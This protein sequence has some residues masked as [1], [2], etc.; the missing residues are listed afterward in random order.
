MYT[1]GGHDPETT[2]AMVHAG[3][4]GQ[5]EKSWVTETYGVTS[6]SSS[7]HAL[8]LR[9]PNEHMS[10]DGLGPWLYVL[11]HSSISHAFSRC[12]V[13]LMG[14]QGGAECPHKEYSKRNTQMGAKPVSGCSEN[15]R[16]KALYQ[17]L[18]ASVGAVVYRARSQRDV[19][20][21]AIHHG[22]LGGSFLPMV[23]YRRLDITFP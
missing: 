1:P 14:A 17:V 7:S 16:A 13:P 9:L 20:R 11:A 22:H 3:Q 23:K 18:P 8:S 15:R 12:R 10:S 2:V 19:R 4:L 5:S 21:L 6:P